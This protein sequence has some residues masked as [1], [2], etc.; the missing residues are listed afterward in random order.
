MAPITIFVTL[1][2]VFVLVRLAPGDPITT[3]L[4]MQ[5]GVHYTPQDIERIKALYGLDQPIYI[6]YV[7]W[8]GEVFRLD[9]GYSFVYNRP[10]T[11]LIISRVQNSLL[12]MCTAFVMSVSIAIPSAVISAVKQYS[13]TDYATT[14]F[15][16]F[17]WSIPSFWYGILM[18][19]ILSSGLR[20][21]P[22]SGI[23]QPG[24]PFS[25]P[26][27]LWHLALPAITLG[28]AG[29]AFLTRITRS[30]MLEVMRQDYITAAR[31]KGLRE[32]IVIYKHGLRNAL[33]PVVTLMAVYI[34][35]LVGGSA[36]VETV[37]AWPGIGA[38]VVDAANF[39]DY[40]TVTG[41]TLM[42]TVSIVV[43]MLIVDISYAYLDPRV[44]Y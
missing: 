15:T 1:S 29:T 3:I 30:S 14:L 8:L 20:L 9:L 26:D 11:S 25:I 19:Q 21:F 28:T 33:L 38:L 24:A 22:T 32:R 39:R 23:S 4:G 10:V 37:F 7:R 43:A 44:K 17:F 18:I 5:P 31:A 40:P 13:K 16:V 6:Q 41:I 36:I 12:L 34:G 35:W 27:L 2:L 42:V